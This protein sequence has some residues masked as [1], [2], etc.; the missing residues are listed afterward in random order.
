MTPKMP[1]GIKPTDRAFMAQWNDDE[2][3]TC[4]SGGERN[5]LTFD[6]ANR[7]AKNLQGWVICYDK[8]GIDSVVASYLPKHRF[9]FFMRDESIREFEAIDAEDALEQLGKQVGKCSHMQRY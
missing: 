2:G 1:K 9:S 3:D 4:E 7:T 5:W 8:D 6:E